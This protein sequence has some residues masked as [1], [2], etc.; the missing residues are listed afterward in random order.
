MRARIAGCGVA[1]VLVLGGCRPA[2]NGP[3]AGQDGTAPPASVLPASAPVA[4]A[5]MPVPVRPRQ[6]PAP[7]AAVAPVSAQRGAPDIPGAVPLLPPQ[8]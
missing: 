8:P 7:L 5:A 3:E 4:D 6:R 1:A 2:G